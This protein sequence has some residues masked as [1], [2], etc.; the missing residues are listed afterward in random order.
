MHKKDE[1]KEGQSQL[2]NTD[3][4]QPLDHPMVI[5]TASIQPIQPIQPIAKIQKSYIKDT[6]DFI[7]FIERKKLPRNTLLVSMDVTSLYTN[8]PQ[9]QGM[10]IVCAAYDKFYK[11]Y[12]PILRLQVTSHLIMRAPQNRKSDLLV[13]KQRELVVPAQ[14]FSSRFE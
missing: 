11:S 1:V 3:H 7:N 4:Y 14:R 5:E 13:D 6:T 2:D 8:I 10:Q 12:P 9:E